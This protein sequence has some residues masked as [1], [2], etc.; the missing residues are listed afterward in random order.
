MTWFNQ[1]TF[2]YPFLFAELGNAWF[3]VLWVY[4]FWLKFKIGE[5]WSFCC[6]NL[7]HHV[8]DK[9][10]FQFIYNNFF[11]KQ[12]ISLASKEKSKS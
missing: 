1:V 5:S 8:N 2:P 4:R 3:T 6:S 7:I 9:F 10:T 12:L 11:F